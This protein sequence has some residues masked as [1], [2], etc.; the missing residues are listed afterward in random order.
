MLGGLV[1]LV[2]FGAARAAEPALK[3]V[4][5][6]WD[7]AYLE[8][9]RAGYFR[10]SVHEVER[11]G[12]KLLRTTVE[13]NLTVKRFNALANLRMESGTEETADGKVKG[14][15]MRQFFDKGQQLV[16][17]G[18]V[19]GDH[20][21]VQVDNGRIDKKVRW[22][23]QVIGLQKQE[24]FFQE[25]KA[26]P[27][28]RFTYHSYE[29]QL[30]TVVTIRATVKGEEEVE[31]LRDRN[32]GGKVQTEFVKERLLRVDAVPDKIEVPGTSV[33]LPGM[34]SWLDR[35]LLSVRTQMEMPPLGKITFHRTTREAA[36][37]QGGAVAQLTDLGL[38]TLIPTNRK[39]AQPHDTRSAVY[40]I[41]VKDDDQVATALASDERQ[42]VKN[43][44]GSTLELHVRSLRAP[45]PVAKPGEP[46]EEFL[47]SSYYLKSD[48]ARIKEQARQAVGAEIDPW[49]KALRIERWVHNNMRVDNSVAFG[50]ADQ[51]ARE[52]RGDCR[53]HALLTAA[54]CRAA[55]VPSRTAVGLVYVNDRQRGPVFGFHMWAEV[56]V[57]GQWLAI[58]AT[59]GQGYVGAAHVKIADHSWH[60]TESLTP[61]LPVARVLGKMSVE[62]VSID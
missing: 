39:L 55:G 46:Q 53:Q 21:L 16:L 13:L 31:V 28:D 12:Q 30:N 24:R 33:Q 51:V 48:D 20:L 34:T 22:N 35:D 50:P 52:L 27:G 17:T 38:A 58:D 14:V 26:K 19:A 2:W 40:R 37:G 42:Q 6:Q 49:K 36:T 43:V 29:P 61:L 32:V 18:V 44:K 8:G 45:Q 25:N 23:D 60:K 10:T 1:L 56:W 11:Q 7:A 3:L 47:A 59:L 9:G 15:F 54:L 62:I 4:K 5:E 57:Q 41:T